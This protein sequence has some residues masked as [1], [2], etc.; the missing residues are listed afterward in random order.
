MEVSDATIDR[1]RDVTMAELRNAGYQLETLEDVDEVRAQ[2][3]PELIDEIVS[4]VEELGDPGFEVLDDY[5]L[6]AEDSEEAEDVDE[7]GDGEVEDS[8]REGEENDAEH[9]EIVRIMG[10]IA[11]ADY[12]V[13]DLLYGCPPGV[14]DRVVHQIV[15]DYG[16][17]CDLVAS[18]KAR[19]N[20]ELSTD[21]RPELGADEEGEDG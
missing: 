16:T 2:G 9:P 21:T 15:A 1:M 8:G 11:D 7:A 12:R 18:H 20:D 10:A 5:D 6:L 4:T 17:A 19:W 3:R 13:G 14:K